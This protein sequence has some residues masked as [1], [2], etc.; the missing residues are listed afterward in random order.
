MADPTPCTGDSV[1]VCCKLPQWFSS[2]GNKSE[3]RN[4]AAASASFIVQSEVHNSHLSKLW[5]DSLIVIVSCFIRR[6]VSLATFSQSA[7]PTIWGGDSLWMCLST[8]KPWTPD[9]V[10][11]L[12]LNSKHRHITRW[13]CWQL[14]QNNTTHEHVLGQLEL[15]I[16]LRGPSQACFT[17]HLILIIKEDNITEYNIFCR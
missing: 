2:Q 12:E 1:P 13:M 10:W 7:L 9:Q 11:R 17:Y 16:W 5:T 8:P 14:R 3:L 6:G 4:P 15:H